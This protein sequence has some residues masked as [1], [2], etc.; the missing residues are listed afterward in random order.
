MKPTIISRHASN[1]VDRG[2]SAI[3]TLSRVIGHFF[4]RPPVDHREW[5]A[6]HA[7]TILGMV[8][9]DATEV[10]IAGYLKS[11]AVE[12]GVEFDGKRGRGAAIAL[13]H[14]GKAALVRD[15]AERVLQGEVPV[16]APTDEPLGAWLTKR[17]LTPEDEVDLSS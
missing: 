15:F 12:L 6:P 2:E 9:A 7:N 14:I 8:E 1:W 16:N 17:L 13:W 10:H 11:V 4:N 5:L 3:P